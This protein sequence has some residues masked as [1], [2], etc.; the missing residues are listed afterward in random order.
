[1]KGIRPSIKA[2]CLII[3]I[4]MTIFTGIQAF[5]VSNK[6]IALSSETEMKIKLE[7]HKQYLEEAVNKLVQEG[8]LSKAKAAEILEY[9]KKKI[10]ELS[11]LTIEQRQQMKKQGKKSSLLKELVQEGVITEAEAQTIRAKLREMKE[12]RIND[13]MQSL[14]DK[15]VLTAKDIENIRNYMVKIRE[16]RKENIDKLKSMTAEERRAYFKQHKK[17]QKDILLKMVEDKVITE[18]QA[19]EIRK[20][21]PELYAP[22]RK[23]SMENR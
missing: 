21:I 11:K 12:T 17:E 6:I 8:K 23:K 5:A 2:L 4:C 13:G 19:K 15:G 3:I 14:V 10:G 9:K 1:M 20:A 18:E 22:M 16:E 7:N